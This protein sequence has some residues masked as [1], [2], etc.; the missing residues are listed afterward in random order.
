M[1]M[2]TYSILRSILF[3]SSIPNTSLRYQI[4]SINEEHYQACSDAPCFLCPGWIKGHCRI[5][6]WFLIANWLMS[7]KLVIIADF[8]G[9]LFMA[10]AQD[11]WTFMR[12][13]RL[14]LIKSFSNDK[15][16]LQ[17]TNFK[18]AVK[19]HWMVVKAFLSP[20]PALLLANATFECCRSDDIEDLPSKEK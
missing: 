17:C 16:N 9:P 2:R 15:L 5:S 11:I 10:R 1:S 4:H 12:N 3:S 6:Y 19:H 8:G 20:A 14:S 7:A 18:T 13:F